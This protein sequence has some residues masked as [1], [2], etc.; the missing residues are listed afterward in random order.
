MASLWS[1]FRLHLQ[2]DLGKVAE[3][4]PRPWQIRPGIPGRKV[5]V[6]VVPLRFRQTGALR[7]RTFEIIRIKE[8]TCLLKL[9]FSNRDM[10][11]VTIRKTFNSAITTIIITFNSFNKLITF[12]DII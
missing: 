5:T 3:E 12:D 8:F 7:Y 9:M 2:W 11:Y 1:L 10:F 4:S 6:S